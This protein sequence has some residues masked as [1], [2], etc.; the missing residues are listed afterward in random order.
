MQRPKRPDELE[1]EAAG[2]PSEPL[3]TVAT[4]VGTVKYWRDNKGHGVI[5]SEATAPWDIWCHFAQIVEMPG[6][7]SLEAGE[8]VVV[9]YVRQDQDSFRYIATRVRRLD[10]PPAASE[11]LVVGPR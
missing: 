4:T 10:P 11:P 8:H 7:R 3:G 6:Y 1:R 5:A 2:V 9:E